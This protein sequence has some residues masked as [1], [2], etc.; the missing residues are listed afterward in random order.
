MSLGAD[1]ERIIRVQEISEESGR[2]R[3]GNEK[4]S[5]KGKTSSLTWTYIGALEFK[6]CHKLYPE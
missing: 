4:K 2:V 3:L 6:L 1:S 5:S